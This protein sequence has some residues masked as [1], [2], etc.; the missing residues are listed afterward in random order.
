MARQKLKSKGDKFELVT[1]FDN[2]EILTEQ[3]SEKEAQEWLRENKY[4]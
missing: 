2:G 3:M 1:Y 4:K